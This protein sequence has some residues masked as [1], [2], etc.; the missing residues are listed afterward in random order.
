[1]SSSNDPEALLIAMSLIA[2]SVQPRTDGVAAHDEMG[3]VA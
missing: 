1:M 3:A 2:G